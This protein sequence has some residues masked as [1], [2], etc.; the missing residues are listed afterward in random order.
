M[1]ICASC[2]SS[3]FLIEPVKEYYNNTVNFWDQLKEEEAKNEQKEIEEKEDKQKEDIIVLK[4][5]Q[6]TQPNKV[7]KPK[8]NH[9]INGSMSIETKKKKVFSKKVNRSAEKI[10]DTTKKIKIGINKPTIHGH[11]RSLDIDDEKK[12]KKPKL[13]ISISNTVVRKKEEERKKDY[14]AMTEQNTVHA[15]K[16]NP[17]IISTKKKINNSL[18]RKGKFLKNGNINN[19]V[20]KF[21]IESAKKTTNKKD[22][23][24]H[25]NKLDN[26][27][28]KGVV[29]GTITESD[30]Y[31]Y[32]KI[33]VD[34]KGIFGNNM[35]NFDCKFLLSNLDNQ[36]TEGLI[37]GL[38]MLAVNQEKEIEKYKEELKI[39]KAN[40][41]TNIYS[42]DETI[43]LLKQQIKRLNSSLRKIST[44]NVS[45][46][47]QLTD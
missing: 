16:Y 28:L 26:E 4:E 41:D 42:K 9:S 43:E 39:S 1:E 30:I 44:D 27:L 45:L 46:L 7:N 36:S 37:K 12:I 2:G 40:L 6:N 22:K 47:N 13:N 18:E 31:S 15:K 10:N 14:Y 20:K 21:S 23:T 33:L 24:I 3:D 17:K 11:A 35:E 34:L 38:V 25:N 19:K 5:I 32:K 8:L 29:N